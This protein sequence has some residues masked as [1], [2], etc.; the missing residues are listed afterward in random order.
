M[1][2][3]LLSDSDGFDALKNESTS[4]KITIPNLPDTHKIS[5]LDN[6]S[7]EHFFLMTAVTW[8]FKQNRRIVDILKTI[9][10][11]HSYISCRRLIKLSR[12]HNPDLRVIRKFPDLTK[13][14]ANIFFYSD[15]FTWSFTHSAWDPWSLELSESRKN[16]T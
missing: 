1:N 16:K 11:S 10:F 5:R 7:G 3:N 8:S 4:L 9:T 6:I 12:Y 2:Y 13:F 15:H 14:R